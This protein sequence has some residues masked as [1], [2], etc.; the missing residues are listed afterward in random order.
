MDDLTKKVLDFMLDKDRT[1]IE[2]DCILSQLDDLIILSNYLKMYEAM[3]MLRA[4]RKGLDKPP[5]K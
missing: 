5:K 4:I 3:D 2:G 1:S